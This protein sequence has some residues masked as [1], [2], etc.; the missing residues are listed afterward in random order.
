MSVSIDSL[1][2][3]LPQ[4]SG[5]SRALTAVGLGVAGGRVSLGDSREREVWGGGIYFLGAFGSWP[6]SAQVI[7]F[8]SLFLFFL[9]L[10]MWYREISRLGVESELQLP[11]YAIATVMLD[12]SL[13]CDLHHSSRQC[14]ILDP[15][16]KAR[17]GTCI[18]TEQIF[19]SALVPALL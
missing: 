4:L 10:L 7:F 15:L 2:V 12:P 6:G 8:L 3:Q 9:R 14:W 18:L 5:L 13:I 1:Q 17:D 19:D 16:S 11:A